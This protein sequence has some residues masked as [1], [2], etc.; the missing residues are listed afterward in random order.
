MKV[1]GFNRFYSTLGNHKQAP[2]GA[3]FAVWKI[4][5]DRPL[6]DIIFRNAYN[7]VNRRDQFRQFLIDKE[8]NNVPTAKKKHWPANTLLK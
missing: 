1:R 2:N 4:P 8:A 6:L 7:K 3:Y 5:A